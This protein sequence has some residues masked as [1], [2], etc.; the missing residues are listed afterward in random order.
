[1]TVA[2][3]LRGTGLG[4]IGLVVVWLC[5]GLLAQYGLGMGSGRESKCEAF[6][7]VLPRTGLY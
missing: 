2:S 4:G 1:M 7:A 6:G 3:E 5:V